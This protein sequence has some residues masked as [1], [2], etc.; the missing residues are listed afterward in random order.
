MATETDHVRNVLRNIW[1][2]AQDC[3][4]TL[5]AGLRAFSQGRFR[6]TSAGRYITSATG[7]GHSVSFLVP[8]G[9]SPHSASEHASRLLD[10]HDE[11]RAALVSS[12]IDAPTDEQVFAEMLHRCKPVRVAIDDFS[13]IRSREVWA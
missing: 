2:G 12:G 4:L 3:A 7:N 6:E 5:S 13:G 10:L 1:W 9:V 11:S 8:T